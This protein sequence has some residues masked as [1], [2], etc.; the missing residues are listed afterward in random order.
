MDVISVVPRPRHLKLIQLD[1]LMSRL[2]DA[3]RQVDV[4]TSMASS[5]VSERFSHHTCFTSSCLLY[6]GPR[7]CPLFGRPRGP[8]FVFFAR[9][10]TKTICLAPRG[11]RHRFM[12]SRGVVGRSSESFSDAHHSRTEKALAGMRD[13]PSLD[14]VDCWSWWS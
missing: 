6:R 11:G 9:L 4:F 1:D 8:V 10:R 13:T 5:A 12:G 7:S 2:F 3:F 14:L